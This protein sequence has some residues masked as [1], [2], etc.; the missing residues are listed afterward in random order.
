MTDFKALEHEYGVP[1]Q[2]KR[3]LVAVSGSGACL[4]DEAGE[5]Y[6]DCV[7][8]IG[9]ASLGHS[10]PAIVA[11]IK[12]QAE[13]LITCPNIM[14]NDVRSNLLKKLIELAHDMNL[15]VVA[16]GVEH[17]YQRDLLVK[18]KCDQL[19]GFLMHKPGKIHPLTTSW[20]KAITIFIHRHRNKKCTICSLLGV[21]QK[22]FNSQRSPNRNMN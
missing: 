3:D 21:C 1:L 10:H 7:G 5:E 2:P 14:Y 18:M 4:Y 12:Q 15:K 19:Q 22:R 9:V 13:T 17:A 16:E 11:A 8:G 6:I 20:L